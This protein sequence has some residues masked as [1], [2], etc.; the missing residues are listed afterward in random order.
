MWVMR[1]SFPASLL[2]WIQNVFA[3]GAKAPDLLSL[4][5][6]PVGVSLSAFQDSRAVMQRSNIFIL[7]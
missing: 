4:I 7:K 2:R 5:N 3:K 1:T 6:S